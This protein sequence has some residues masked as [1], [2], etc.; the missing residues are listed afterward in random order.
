MFDEG[1]EEGM[2]MLF[3]TVEGVLNAWSLVLWKRRED[4]DVRTVE[5]PNLP[6]GLTDELRHDGELLGRV[7]GLARAVEGARAETVGV[8]FVCLFVSEGCSL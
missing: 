8:L 5:T 2:V 1:E 3:W 4:G 7:D 6:Y